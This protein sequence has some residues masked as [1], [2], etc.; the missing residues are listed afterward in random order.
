[1]CQNHFASTSLRATRAIRVGIVALICLSLSSVSQTNPT[2]Q[3]LENQ[4][5]Q[6]LKEIESTNKALLTTIQT[7][8]T[9]IVEYTTML[10]KIETRELLI[11]NLMKQ[12]VQTDETIAYNSDLS[13]LLED[14]LSR[15]KIDYS[16]L[17]RTAYRQYSTG[18]ALFF[19]FMSQSFIQAFQRWQY[20]KQ[21]DAQRKQQVQLIQQAQNELKTKANGLQNTLV[22]K[23]QLLEFTKNQRT[24]LK[25]ELQKKDS[26]ILLLQND[27]QRIRADLAAQER[28]HAY[29]FESI[30]QLI[31]TEQSKENPTQPALVTTNTPITAVILPE[32]KVIYEASVIAKEFKNNKGALPMPVQNGNIIRNFGKQP[33]PTFENVEISNNGIDIKCAANADIEVI[34]YGK[35]LGTQYIP[36]YQNMVLVQHGTFYTVYSNMETVIVKRGDIVVAKQVIGKVSAEKPEVHFEI[37]QDKILLNPANWVLR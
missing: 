22:A 36:G 37:W 7:K 11:Q 34:F 16:R 18:N 10:K 28:T 33:H 3:S 2:Q 6:L 9:S 13:R 24:D 31:Q 30:Q 21:Y 14:D 15:L 1:M 20:V 27:E 26:L 19:I 8:Q 25:K 29:L 35:V 23:K 5:I 4:R 32:N 12:L 17:L